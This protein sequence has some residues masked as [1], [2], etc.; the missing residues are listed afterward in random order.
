M[1]YL[2]KNKMG[3]RLLEKK[4]D[5]LERKE[6]EIYNYYDLN[7]KT[8]KRH[9]WIDDLKQDYQRDIKN[10]AFPRYNLQRK[11][12]KKRIQEKEE[13]E[14]K[15]KKYMNELKKQKNEIIESY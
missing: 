5:E 4:F 13:I 12:L 6:L 2:K 7:N 11:F 14:V 9:V 3:L 1:G 8:S 10:F 15:V